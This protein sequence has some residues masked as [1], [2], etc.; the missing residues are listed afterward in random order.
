MTPSK[1]AL[2]RPRSSRSVRRAGA[3]PRTRA[4]G[5]GGKR[6]GDGSLSGTRCQSPPRDNGLSRPRVPGGAGR[7]G[8]LGLGLVVVLVLWAG[9]AWGQTPTVT[10]AISPTAEQTL[11]E[12]DSLSFTITVSNAT[13]D[14][15]GFLGIRVP[16]TSE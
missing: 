9:A 15:I 6:S 1:P 5:A 12:G 10:V 2:F 4:G 13:S 7:R 14:H 3:P 16:R 8:L 11:Q